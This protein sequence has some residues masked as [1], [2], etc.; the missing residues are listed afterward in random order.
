MNENAHPNT[1]QKRKDVIHLETDIVGHHA[2]HLVLDD[3]IVLHVHIPK[4][5]AAVII[6]P[7]PIADDVIR[8]VVL[9]QE[10]EDAVLHLPQVH[11][12]MTADIVGHLDDQATDHPAAVKVLAVI[13]FPGE[14]IVGFLDQLQTL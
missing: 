13:G 3:V 10:E 11:H 12:Q 2:L 4:G 1:H 8:H 14:K 7:V 5:G 9:T 6:H